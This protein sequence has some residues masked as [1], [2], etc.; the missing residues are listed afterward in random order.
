MWKSFSHFHFKSNLK[1]YLINP[2][3]TDR[4]ARSDIT[5]SQIYKIFFY[6]FIIFCVQAARLCRTRIRTKKKERKKHST[7]QKSKTEEEEKKIFSIIYS[8]C[9]LFIFSMPVISSFLVHN[10]KL[11]EI[12]AKFVIFCFLHCGVYASL[13]RFLSS[14][15]VQYNKISKW[16]RQNKIY[17][18]WVW[19]S[20]VSV[21]MRYIRRWY[22]TEFNAKAKLK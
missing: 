17:W 13:Y 14:L 19:V 2:C 7:A 12:R 1:I 3:K 18:Q 8:I 6:N 16:I 11:R 21:C 22:S 10:S 5:H 15:G 9:F 4:T 20:A